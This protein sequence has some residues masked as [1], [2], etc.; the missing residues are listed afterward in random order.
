[1]PSKLVDALRLEYQ[2]VS[3]LWQDEK[4][5]KALEFREGK[6]GCL[7][8]HLVAAAR[9]KVAVVSRKTYGCP[10]GGVGMGLGN[11]YEN[12]AGGEEGFYR[13]L[14]EGNEGLPGADAIAGAMTSAGQ[15]AMAEE[16]LS[17]ERYLKDADAARRFVA[18]LGPREIPAE[19]VVM[20]PLEEGDLDNPLVQS[21][22]FF[23]NADQL[24]GLAVLSHY[25]HPDKERVI[26]PFAAGCQAAGLAL[27]N[28]QKREFPRAVVGLVDISARKNIRHLMAA[29]L[30]TF[31]VTPKMFQELESHVEGSFLE[32]ENWQKLMEK[33]NNP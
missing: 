5:E 10:G 19:Y 14:S 30:L 26:V 12:F 27:Y 23:V 7:M 29:D 31:S 2:P 20:R 4:P 21:I 28:E 1:M 16:F 6:W 24:S 9:G 22:T 11:C 25:E 18:H 32:Q 17:G 8:F 15:K 13:F 33:Q 3:L